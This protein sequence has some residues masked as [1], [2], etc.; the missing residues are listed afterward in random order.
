[1]K[2]SF[3]VCLYLW[4]WTKKVFLTF[5]VNAVSSQERLLFKK[6]FFGP[7]KCGFN[8][9]EVTKTERLLMARV[10]YCFSDLKIVRYVKIVFPL[11]SSFY[12]ESFTQIIVKQPIFFTFYPN[13]A[14]TLWDFRMHPL[15]IL[16]YE[17][18]VIQNVKSWTEWKEMLLT[19]LA[20]IVKDWRF[21]KM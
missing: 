12:L 16:W 6:N 2:R 7:E 17:S 20:Q 18:S 21:P 11:N 13:E 3:F 10:R 4:K 14:Y 5:H 8:L 9:R 1:M 15:E 19:F